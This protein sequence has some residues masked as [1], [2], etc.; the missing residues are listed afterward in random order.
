MGSTNSGL[1]S[2]ALGHTPSGA[3]PRDD[4]NPVVSFTL[5]FQ[6]DSHAAVEVHAVDTNSGIILDTEIDVFADT[7]AE[8]ASLR[9]VS[10]S[11]LVFLDLKAALEDL[12]SLGATDSDMDSDLFVT[13]DTEGTDGVASLA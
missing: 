3:G 7:E 1:A 8:V 5:D 11:Q 10:L 13:A 4:I 12:L 2:S 9:E 6:V